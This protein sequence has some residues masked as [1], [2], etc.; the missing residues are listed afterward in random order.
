MAAATRPGTL[1]IELGANVLGPG[2][3]ALN[4]LSVMDAELPR[5]CRFGLPPKA[6]RMLPVLLPID[7][8]DP[9]LTMRFVCI[10][11]IGTGVVACERKAAA[12]AAAESAELVAL[13][14]LAKACAAAAEAADGGAGCG[15]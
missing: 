4:V 12:A 7:D 1:G 2:D 15:C 11:L 5:R 8:T 6:W 3:G 9:L 13:C 14:C 10:S